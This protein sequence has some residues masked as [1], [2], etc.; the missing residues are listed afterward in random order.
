MR[1]GDRIKAADTG[2]PRDDG[3]RARPAADPL[4]EFKERAREA[5]FAHLDE[6]GFDPA[7]AEADLRRTVMAE[8]TQL[9]AE[10]DAP[11]TA[12]ERD[13]LA[14]EI[15]ED[16][17]GYGPIERFLADDSVTEVMVNATDPIF[18]ERDGR[19]VQTESAFRSAAHVRHVIERIVSRVGRRIDEASPMVDARLPDGS[20]V[21]AVI[22]PLAVDGPSLTIRKFA[23]DPFRTDDLVTM[24]TLTTPMARLLESCVKGRLN[25]LISGGT[26]TGKTTL[27]N[28]VSSFI[29]DDQRIVTIEDAVELQLDQRHVVRLE[30]RPPNV[31][32]KGEVTIRDLVRNALRMRPDRIVVGEVRGP[33]ALDMLQAMNT[34]HDGS[35]STLHANSP[36]DALSRLETMVMMAGIEIPISAVRDYLASALSV[37]VHLSRMSDGSRRVTRVSEIVGMEGEVVTMQDLFTFR[38]RG[39]DEAGRVV[40]AVVPTGIR[41]KFADQLAAVGHPLPADLF[42]AADGRA[43]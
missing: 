17:L 4:A 3:G 11:L 2:R 28:V 26:G 34:G 29:P 33:E 1:L 37:I 10:G 9:M 19:I 27:L 22:P 16:I 7:V 5:L 18:I 38:Q 12:P 32:G 31:E 35:L 41:P 36:R 15:S 39:V 24:G 13:R 20:R 14:S 21:N 30:A 40:G 6:Q 8:L 25:L 43:A 23:R 42:T